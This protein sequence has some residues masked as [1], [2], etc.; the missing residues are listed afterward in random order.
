M[1]KPD[2]NEPQFELSLI[3]GASLLGTV[4]AFLDNRVEVD[5]RIVKELPAGRNVRKGTLLTAAVEAL[6]KAG[7]SM[8]INDLKSALLKTGTTKGSADHLIY[9]PRFKKLTI[10]VGD[11]IKLRKGKVSK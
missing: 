5:M 8:D 4:L 7:G 10:R 3:V 1:K 2:P 9:T 6:T 11:T